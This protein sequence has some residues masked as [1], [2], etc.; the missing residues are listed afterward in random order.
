MQNA[1]FGSYLPWEGLRFIIF[2]ISVFT[3]L[4][5]YLLTFGLFIKS[6]HRWL[7]P[8]GIIFHIFLYLLLPIRTFRLTMILLYI[9]FLD[10]NDV[11][12]FLKRI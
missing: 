6:W 9:S 2:L 3:V 8:V 10:P 1:Y 4:I 12:Y 11:H 5:L 7:M